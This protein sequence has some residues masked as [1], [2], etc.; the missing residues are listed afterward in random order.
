MPTYEYECRACGW[1][2]EKQQGMTEAPLAKCPQCGGDVHRLISG[3]SGFIMN[4][5]Q[6][7]SGHSSGGC[8]LET[9]G[10][11]CCGR[12]ERCDKP[13]CGGETK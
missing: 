5:G 4:G 10:R 12:S 1:R 3:G 2:F 6:G 7:R 8:S 13:P 9:E 11:T